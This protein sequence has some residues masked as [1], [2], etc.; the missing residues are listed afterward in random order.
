MSASVI[1]VTAY[2]DLVATLRDEASDLVIPKPFT[3]RSVERAV[4]TQM[5]MA[6]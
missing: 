6:A 1:F 5:L 4:Q 3:F 2:P